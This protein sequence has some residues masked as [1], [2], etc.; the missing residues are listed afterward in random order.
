VR[1]FKINAF[2]E[3]QMS[4]ARTPAPTDT[5]ADQPQSYEAAVAELE[6]LVARLESG[7]MPLSELLSGY[8][9]GAVLLAY[10]RDQL[11]AVENQIQVLDNGQL[12]PWDEA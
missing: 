12:K 3:I 1:A 8:Q 7:Q 11:Q 10:C 9:R 4:K 5:V 6:S 2:V